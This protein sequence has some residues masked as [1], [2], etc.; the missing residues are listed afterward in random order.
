M[1]FA[2][3]CNL[4]TRSAQATNS[5]CLSGV[6]PPVFDAS[7]PPGSASALDMQQSADEASSLQ[8]SMEGPSRRYLGSVLHRQERRTASGG[9]PADSGSRSLSDIWTGAASWLGASLS[10]GHLGTSAGSFARG[11][12]SLTP[13]GGLGIRWFVSG[14]RRGSVPSN[15]FTVQPFAVAQQATL[16]DP[17]SCPFCA[18]RR[19]AV[20]FLREEA[21][22]LT[23][24]LREL[25]DATHPSLRESL[26]AYQEQDPASGTLVGGEK[27]P[28][29]GPHRVLSAAAAALSAAASTAASAAAGALSGAREGVSCGANPQQWDVDELLPGSSVTWGVQGEKKSEKTASVKSSG[30][31]LR[32]GQV[33]GGASVGPLSSAGV[34]PARAASG[35]Y[36][37]EGASWLAG[38]GRFLSVSSHGASMSDALEGSVSSAAAAAP[39]VGSVALGKEVLCRECESTAAAV[40]TWRQEVALRDKRC[41]LAIAFNAQCA[42][43]VEALLVSSYETRTSSPPRARACSPA[44]HGGPP[45][46]RHGAAPAAPEAAGGAAKGALAVRLCANCGNRI[47]TF[48]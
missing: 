28:L 14:W 47:L 16:V 31:V 42:D 8:S 25:T 4:A 9:T 32:R 30:A 10:E 22:R 12:A 1:S 18:E 44:T 26:Q 35:V 29:G 40:S 20:R 21:T 7:Q 46:G 17:K 45:A 19:A 27:G 33:R 41:L 36:R 11:S 34:A 13:E 3:E 38:G 5:D 6:A 15:K 37:E 2:R 48:V 24:E 39:A 23:E 43:E